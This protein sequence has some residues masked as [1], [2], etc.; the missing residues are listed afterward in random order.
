MLTFR[1]MTLIFF[2]VLLLFNLARILFCPG[3]CILREY[4]GEFYILWI[5]IYLGVS[6]TF[7]FL[8]CSGF[9]HPVI[10]SGR[11]D[12]KEVALT[13]DDGPHQ[14]T[15]KILGVLERRNVKATFFVTGKHLEQNSE[16]A[17]SI[18]FKGHIMGNHTWSHSWWFDFF[19]PGKMHAELVRTASLIETLTG[20]KPLFF[21]PPYGV[22][23]PMLSRAL[24]KLPWSVICWNIRSF[25][26]VNPNPQLVIDKVVRKLKPGAIIALHDHTLFSDQHLERLIDLVSENGYRIVPLDQ[27]LQKPAYA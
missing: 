17:E 12:L 16:I 13:F 20:K 15:L 8:P 27:L 5:G 1:R 14:Q 22:I 10:C 3:N 26:T 23:N 25:D 18:F 24:R 19:S 4:M 2:I 11:S 7:A 6:V 21:R 9:H